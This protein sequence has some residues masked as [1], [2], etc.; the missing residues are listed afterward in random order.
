M[1]W[2]F[3]EDAVLSKMSIFEQIFALDVMVDNRKLPS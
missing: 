1:T 3:T 2:S